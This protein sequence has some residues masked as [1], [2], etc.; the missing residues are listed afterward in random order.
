VPKRKGGSQRGK[1]MAIGDGSYH[2]GKKIPLRVRVG[3]EVM[4]SKYGYEEVTVDDKEYYII[5]E[6]TILAIIQ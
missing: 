3:D 6:D 4:F 1:V 5:K 2:D